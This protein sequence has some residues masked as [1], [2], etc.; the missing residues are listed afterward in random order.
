MST[1]AEIA[2]ARVLL[3]TAE[4]ESDPEQETRHIDEALILLETAEAST[5][6]ELELIANLRRSYARRLLTKVPRLRSVP[7]EVWLLYFNVLGTLSSEVDALTA[8]DPGLRA[9][10]QEFAGM[11]GPEVRAAI[12][13]SNAG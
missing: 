3:E 1:S 13:R 7:F 9:N 2:E 6:E 5:P 4:R 12:E 8:A 10:R 11:W